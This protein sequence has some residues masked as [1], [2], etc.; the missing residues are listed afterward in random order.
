MKTETFR[1]FGSRLAECFWNECF[2][3]VGQRNPFFGF[4][5]FLIRSRFL[6][7]LIFGFMRVFG[8]SKSRRVFTSTRAARSFTKG[9][10]DSDSYREFC[11]FFAN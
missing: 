5:A 6:T 2:E 4:A 7:Y 3:Q 1:I 11:D 10:F 9:P 8:F